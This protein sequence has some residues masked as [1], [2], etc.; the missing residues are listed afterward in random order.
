MNDQANI[1]LEKIKKT[2]ECLKDNNKVRSQEI[3]VSQHFYEIKKTLH[4]KSL[5]TELKF[6][7]MVVF[8]TCCFL[9][10]IVDEVS[11]CY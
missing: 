1:K 7:S 11:K 4:S 2:L 9:Y 5:I 10:V 3:Q 8:G 6:Y